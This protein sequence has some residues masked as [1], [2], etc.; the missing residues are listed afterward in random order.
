MNYFLVLNLFLKCFYTGKI[1]SVR[2]LL[3]HPVYMHTYVHAGWLKEACLTRDK[4]VRAC[5]RV[6]LLAPARQWASKD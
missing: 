2:F 3:M 6:H 4:A 5:C 1:L